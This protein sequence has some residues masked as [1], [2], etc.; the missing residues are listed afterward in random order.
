VPV[1]PRNKCCRGSDR[2]DDRIN[3]LTVIVRGGVPVIIELDLLGQALQRLL[4]H[5]H[6]IPR[7]D[8]LEALGQL[9][10]QRLAGAL[11]LLVN[12][13]ETV[14]NEEG[15]LPRPQLARRVH[16]VLQWLSW[17]WG[18]YV[19]V[20]CLLGIGRVP[21]DNLVSRTLDGVDKEIQAATD[22]WMRVHD[23]ICPVQAY[24][25]GSAAV[26]SGRP[27]RDG[28]HGRICQPRL[29]RKDGLEDQVQAVN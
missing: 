9:G 6:P 2:H 13:V 23:P 27:V 18:A 3:D 1:F 17:G 26:E 5:M 11:P 21:I 19:N 15:F 14:T 12:V 25:E 8:R 10:D 24:L 29:G 16:S 7:R 28:N 22:G 4:V 20:I